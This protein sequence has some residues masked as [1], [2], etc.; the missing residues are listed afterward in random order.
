M[1]E[2]HPPAKTQYNKKGEREAEASAPASAVPNPRALEFASPDAVIR[3]SWWR[4]LAST[5]RIV[6]GPQ[7]GQ[8]G[9]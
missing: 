7:L 4:F 1:G 2:N 5:S 3:H 8:I 9:A 6:Q